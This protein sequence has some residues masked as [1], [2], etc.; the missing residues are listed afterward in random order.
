ML[1]SLASVLLFVAQTSPEQV[2]QLRKLTAEDPKNAR[3][4][5]T[6]GRSWA[7]LA[8]ENYQQLLNKV[9]PDSACALAVKA[10]ALMHRQQYRWA[11]VLF[12]EALSKDPN[13]ASAR[14]AIAEIYRADG[15]SDWAAKEE[16]LF[17]NLDCTIYKLACD[18]LKGHYD[19]VIDATANEQTPEALYWRGEAFT[20]LSY[21]AFTKLMQLPPSPEMYRF[22][23]G[24]QY[25]AGHRARV[26]EELRKA[27][28]LAPGDQG[29][30]R[31]LA[32]AL[33]AAGDFAAA[34][35]L[36]TKLLHSDPNSAELNALAGDSLL[37][38][39]KTLEAIP[40]LKKSIAVAPKNLMTHSSLARA[41]MQMG[42]AKLALPH[43]E[44]AMPMDRDGSLQYQLALAYRQTGQPERAAKAMARYQE[45]S[46]KAAVPP[47]PEITA[48][49]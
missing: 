25:E 42:E 15:H 13:L 36:A 6:L 2:Q 19:D 34:Y 31:D 37:N 8:A 20:G 39:Q 49:N 27:I 45:L 44:A 22:Q 12:R 41:Y 29:L 21:Q 14:S 38:Q 47:E 46:A 17:A 11:F 4:W 3:A 30:Q 24:L 10:D 18:S 40:F 48:P 16:A 33:G 32:M 1:I 5:Y 7:D 23:A 35:Q 26:V 28:E 9:A 43:L